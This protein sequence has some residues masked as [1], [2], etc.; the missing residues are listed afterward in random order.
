MACGVFIVHRLSVF[1]SY[2]LTLFTVE[3][4]LLFCSDFIETRMWQVW[5]LEI[6]IRD[7]SVDSIF[8]FLK[9][10]KHSWQNKTFQ[11]PFWFC[12]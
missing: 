9:K 1:I 12:V 8:N 7:T 3:H 4:T 11:I 6:L 2:S 10:D 5:S